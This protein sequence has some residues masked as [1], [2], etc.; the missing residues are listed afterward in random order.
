LVKKNTE[1]IPLG[2]RKSF[3]KEIEY[4]LVKS[5]DS[6]IAILITKGEETN[7]FKVLSD[8]KLEEIV[9]YMERMKQDLINNYNMENQP[10]TDF[11]MSCVR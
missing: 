6:F 1:S 10:K 8:L 3:A 11:P 9:G 5:K 7:K 2:A 4:N